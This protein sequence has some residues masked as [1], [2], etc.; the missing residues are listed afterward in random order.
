MLTTLLSLSLGFTPL[1]ARCDDD[2]AKNKALVSEAVALAKK[3]LPSARATESCE[4]LGEARVVALE[5]TELKVGAVK[6]IVHGRAFGT[7]EGAWRLEPFA[8]LAAAKDLARRIT[9]HP[10]VKKALPAK[11]T[12]L[13]TT[14][15]PGDVAWLLC[16]APADVPKE[17][18]EWS[19][20]TSGHLE[21]EVTELEFSFDPRGSGGCG[22]EPFALLNFSVPLAKA[23]PDTA[24]WCQVKDSSEV[25][26]FLS[27]TKE[28]PQLTVARWHAYSAKL[29]LKDGTTHEEKLTP[30]DQDC[31]CTPPPS[32]AK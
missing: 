17:D 14:S 32:C 26:K 6:F 19:T 4:L 1:P 28:S 5:P 30:T 13:A 29:R 22:C 23:P 9:S 11:L 27:K 3:L 10:L 15:A 31:A 21:G 25:K 8:D 18:Y 16:R 12:C 7:A 24:G 2:P 20:P